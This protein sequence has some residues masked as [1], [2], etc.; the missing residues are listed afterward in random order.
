MGYS[1]ENITYQLASQEK[2]GLQRE[3]KMA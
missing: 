3:L 1:I 2:I